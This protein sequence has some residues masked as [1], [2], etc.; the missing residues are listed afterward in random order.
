MLVRRKY[1]LPTMW[2][3]QTKKFDIEK[4]R[5]EAIELANDYG[6]VM[7]TNKALCSNNCDLVESVYKHFKQVNLTEFNPD[8]KAPTLEECRELCDTAGTGD[9]TLTRAQKYKLRTQRTD[10]LDPALDERN[11]NKPTENYTGS[12]FEEVVKS[13]NSDAIRVRLVRLDPGK[14]LS[15]HI[16]YDPTYAIRVIVPIFAE[17]EA[18]NY[19]WRKGKTES[20]HLVPDGSAY[21]LNIGLRHTVINTGTRPR[22][23]LMF[24]LKDQQDIQEIPEQDWNSTTSN[25]GNMVLSRNYDEHK[26]IADAQPVAV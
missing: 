1:Q 15:P 25:M 14:T 12:Y 8:H 6:N 13:F 9:H 20:F 5:D 7:E 26:V 23:S 2:K 3:F 22:I 16:D 18:T 17:E 4:L 11:Y 10:Q 24:S 21:F 19:F